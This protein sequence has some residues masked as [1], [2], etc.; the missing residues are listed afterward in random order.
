[1][2][3]IACTFEDGEIYWRGCWKSREDAEALAE[4]FERDLTGDWFAPFAA[5]FARQ[6]RTAIAAYDD[7]HTEQRSAA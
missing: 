5:N 3:D 2:E 1:M 6:I 7:F 4:H